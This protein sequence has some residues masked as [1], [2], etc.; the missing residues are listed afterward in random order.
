MEV[1]DLDDNGDAGEQD[2]E[3]FLAALF[4]CQEQA[5][6]VGG[7]ERFAPAEGEASFLGNGRG[8]AWEGEGCI[9]DDVFIYLVAQLGGQV[10]E[11]RAQSARGLISLG[12]AHV[13]T[14]VGPT[15]RGVEHVPVWTA[16]FA[17]H[18]GE[19]CGSAAKRE[20]RVSRAASIKS[21]NANV[22]SRGLVRWTRDASNARRGTKLRNLGEGDGQGA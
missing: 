2:G 11:G 13:Y 4:G 5:V 3:I 12:G 6:D 19:G 16:E 20:C 21:S 17:Q 18:V 8:I 15:R 10:E 7:R 9:G 22:V 1:F 14:T